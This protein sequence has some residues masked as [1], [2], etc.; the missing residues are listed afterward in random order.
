M[1]SRGKCAGSGRRAGLRRS[2]DGTVILLGCRHALRRGLLGLRR[3]LFQV[4]KLQLKLIEQR[5]T[6]RGLSELLVPQ[7]RD[8]E[9]ELLDQSMSRA[10]ASASALAQAGRSF[11]RS[12]IAFSVVTSSGRESYGAHRTMESQYAGACL[13]DDRALDSQSLRSAGRMSAATSVAA[14]ANRCLRAGS[15]AAP[16]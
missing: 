9:L 14:S 15:Q 1:R 7:L 12:N 8:R 16:A 13:T 10:W 5:A 3:I 11:A 4:G 6:L 2:N